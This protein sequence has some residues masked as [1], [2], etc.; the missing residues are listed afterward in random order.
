[1]SISLRCSFISYHEH[2]EINNNLPDVDLQEPVDSS[3]LSYKDKKKDE[4]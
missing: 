4:E 2:M 1:M 3:Q